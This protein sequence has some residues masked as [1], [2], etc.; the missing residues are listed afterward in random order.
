V[1]LYFLLA[2]SQVVIK[3]TCYQPRNDEE[4]LGGAKDLEKVPGATRNFL[5]ARKTLSRFPDQL[6]ASRNGN[7]SYV[8]DG[9]DHILS[10]L[11]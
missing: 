2:R 4:V 6:R 10:V 7:D 11:S 3:K 5:E 1:D 8:P 9:A